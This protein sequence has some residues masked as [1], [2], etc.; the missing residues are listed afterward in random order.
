[1]NYGSIASLYIFY[2][3]KKLKDGQLGHEYI[4]TNWGR[5]Y[6]LEAR[7]VE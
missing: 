3:R 7:K 4:R 2:L 5:G 1:M 6:W